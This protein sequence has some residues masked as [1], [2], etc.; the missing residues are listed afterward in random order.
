MAAGQ[1][2]HILY[3]DDEGGHWLQ[4]AVPVSADLTALSFPDERQG[5]AVGHE[6][7]VLHT[8]DGGSTWQRQLDGPQIS[9][10]LARHGLAEDPA[11]KGA[12]KPLMD[13]FFED[14]RHGFVVGAFN[15]M[16]RTEDGGR[17][18]QPWMDRSDNPKGLHLYAIRPACGT[19]FVVGEQGL[20][21]RLD[22]EGQR[23]VRVALPY[24]GTLFG[25]VGGDD[26]VLVFGL[27]GNA[28]RNPGC[29]GE[30][31]RART[32]VEAALTSGVMRSDGSVLLASQAGQI[33]VSDDKGESFEQVRVGAPLPVFAMSEA[34]SARVA[35]AGP[36]GVR[37]ETVRPPRRVEEVNARKKP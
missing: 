37:I 20:V 6:G 33:L 24:A 9:S 30:W 10:V 31:T 36:G 29:S 18:W 35:F 15:L 21:M 32:G 34:D 25:M 13:V 28:W 3:S 7:V 8:T 4:A 11:M 19:V 16:L 22:P 1:R 17:S 5:W 27:R 2:G 26:S 14:E 23:F 12:D